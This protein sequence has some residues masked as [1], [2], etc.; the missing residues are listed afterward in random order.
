MKNIC[1]SFIGGGSVLFPGD[2]GYP[3]PPSVG[4]GYQGSGYV[5][6]LMP[7]ALC[8]QMT[9]Q[10]NP[11]NNPVTAVASSPNRNCTPLARQAATRSAM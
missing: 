7:L 4:E 9:M 6:A 5:E 2:N 10:S 3:N 1:N 11:A 8:Y